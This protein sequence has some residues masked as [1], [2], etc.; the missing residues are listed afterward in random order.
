MPIPDS[1]NPYHTEDTDFLDFILAYHCRNSLDKYLGDFLIVYYKKENPEDQSLWN[2]DTARLTYIVRQ[3][4]HNN[5][6]DWVI[7]KKGV[8]VKEYI[9]DPLMNHIKRSCEEYVEKSTN[10]KYFMKH[11]ATEC[12]SIMNKIQYC[13]TLIKDITDGITSDKIVKYLAPYF[14]LNNIKLAK[15]NMNDE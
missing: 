10:Y 13:T 7:D 15:I 2:S 12:E 4:L 1:D 14:Y 11:T 5:K 8:K 9:I 6:T 3:L